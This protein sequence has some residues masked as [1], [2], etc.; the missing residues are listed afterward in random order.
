MAE[1]KAERVGIMGGTF[2]PIHY[3]HL[4][5][6]ETAREAF[7]LDKIIFVPAGI[8]YFKEKTT[9]ARHRYLMT[10]LAIMSNP[11]FEISRV[12]LDRGGVTY[13]VDTLTDLKK[14]LPSETKMYFIVG[15]DAILRSRTG[16]HQVRCLYGGIHR[17]HSPGI[18]PGKLSRVLGPWRWSIRIGFTSQRCRLWV[19]LRRKSATG[20]PR[21]ALFDIC[22][23]DGHYVYNNEGLYRHNP[24]KVMKVAMLAVEGSKK[25][26][27]QMISADRYT[28]SLGVAEAAT[29]VGPVVW[30]Q[31]GKARIA[32]LVHDCGKSESKNILLNRVLEFGI[33]MDEIEQVETQLLHGPVS[34]ELARR[35]FGIDDEEVLS[36]IRYHTTGRVWMSLLEKIVYLADYI[37]PGRC[38]TGVD[39][40]RELACQDLDTALIRA[41]DLTLTHVMRRG[42]LIHPRTVKARN[43][44]IENSKK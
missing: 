40:L 28:H 32:G 10:L 20:W 34:A 7:S 29:Q 8:P 23:R 36:A 25:R 15:A 35:E 30:C 43:C 12:D 1:V 18:Q 11:Y 13:T 41:M 31:C 24:S 37:E 42:L 2:D 38:F 19:Y 3:G 44:L 14:G 4:V 5:A 16:N 9:P 17:S 33:V 6:A 22:S 39:E 21:V 27:Q 26:L